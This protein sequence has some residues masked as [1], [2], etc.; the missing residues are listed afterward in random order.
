MTEKDPF[1]DIL[2]KL[3]DMVGMIQKNQD[4]PMMSTDPS[5]AVI[6]ALDKLETYIS[7]FKSVNEE[8]LKSAGLPPDVIKQK[9]VNADKE[10]PKSTQRF[11]E[12]SEK[13][14][15]DVV[16][17][18]NFYMVYRHAAEMRKK[19]QGKGEFGQGRKKKF[20]RLSGGDKGWMPL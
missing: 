9:I 12:R 7:V 18:E 1:D 16:K 2:E 20:K 5:P 8:A 6:K 13:L 19:R 14:K 17:L 15:Q 10:L 3:A 11:L 4:K